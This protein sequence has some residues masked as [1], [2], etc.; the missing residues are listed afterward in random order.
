MTLRNRLLFALLALALIP[1]AVFTWFTLDQL[2]RSIDRWYRPGVA[3]ALE[4]GLEIGKGSLAR[5]ESTLLAQSDLWASRWTGSLSKAVQQSWSAQLAAA[6]VDFL[7][8][9]RR[10][11]DGSWQ[12]IAQQCRPVRPEG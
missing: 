11:P 5:F 6:G 12:R 4:A 9:Y 1:T 8:V 3:R 7:Q 2:G 10:G